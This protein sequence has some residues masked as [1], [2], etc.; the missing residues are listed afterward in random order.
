M[1]DSAHQMPEPME[2]PLAHGLSPVVGFRVDA[3]MPTP[4]RLRMSWVTSPATTPA[5]TPPQDTL[6][7]RI[8]RASSSGLTGVRLGSPRAG[9]TV[10]LMVMEVVLWAR[11]G[12]AP[13]KEGRRR[14][15]G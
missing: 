5:S 8:V 4:I 7:I 14:D 13:R 1:P 15:V 9:C 10:S 12:P 11:T 6:L 3:P 2:K